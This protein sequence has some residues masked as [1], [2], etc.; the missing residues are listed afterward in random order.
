MMHME[1]SL[2][3]SLESADEKVLQEILRQA[4]VYIET[5]TAVAT[6]SD[7]RALTFS[8]LIMAGNVILVSSSYALATSD[9]T[10]LFLAIVT[11]LLAVALFASAVLSVLSARSVDWGYPGGQPDTWIDDVLNGTTLTQ[12]LAEQCANY[13]DHIIANKAAMKSNSEMFNAA[14]TLAFGASGFAGI[15]YLYWFSSL[16]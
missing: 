10:N 8:G 16:I 1:N 7:A 3:K 9:P 6:A 11:G 15:A 14:T 5:Q 4:E 13:N 2:A 12:A